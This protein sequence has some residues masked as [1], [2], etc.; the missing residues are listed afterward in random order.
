MS[1][2]NLIKNN[3]LRDI[4][5]ICVIVFTTSLIIALVSYYP[6]IS[7]IL[8]PLGFI[9][10]FSLLISDQDSLSDFMQGFVVIG[11]VVTFWGTLFFMIQSQNEFILIAT[12]PL[13]CV[14]FL[15]YLW[16]IEEGGSFLFG[17]ISLIFFVINAI[18]SHFGLISV[19]LT[20]ISLVVLTV[21]IYLFEK[22]NNWEFIGI[23]LAFFILTVILGLVFLDSRSFQQ[24]LSGQQLTTEKKI[25]AQIQKD[26]KELKYLINTYFDSLKQKKIISEKISPEFELKNKK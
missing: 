5:Y 25:D 21:V 2:N 24:E 8:M 22:G 13:G 12:M 23:I 3:D 9:F 7:S 11:S 1:L 16:R 14:F 15:V 4:M 6:N 17:V 19:V 20:P 18:V 26:S 10:T